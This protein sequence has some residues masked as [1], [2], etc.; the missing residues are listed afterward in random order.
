MK[1]STNGLKG[2]PEIKAAQLLFNAV[3]SEIGH[4]AD[5]ISSL[6]NAQASIE[7]KCKKL[8]KIRDEQKVNS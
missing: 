5:M 2:Y 4:I 7:I 6:K 1:Y 8:Q 3:M